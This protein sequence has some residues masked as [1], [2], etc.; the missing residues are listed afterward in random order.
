M[1]R[2]PAPQWE[3]FICSDGYNLSSIVHVL[4]AKRGERP[5]KYGQL[6]IHDPDFQEKVTTMKA[7]A[8]ERASAL[9]AVG[10]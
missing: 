7:E 9:R 4:I 1:R 5:I 2:K 8:E 6:E 10:A 3:V